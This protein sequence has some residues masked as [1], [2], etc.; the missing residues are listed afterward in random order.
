MR[1]VRSE[2]QTPSSAQS[3]AL[4]FIERNGPASVSEMAAHRHVKHQSMRLVIAQLEQQQLVAR[5][6]DPVDGRKQLIT[7]TDAGHAALAQG[8]TLRSDWLAS[9]LRQ[10]ATATQLDTL[11]AAVEILE[12]L[13]TDDERG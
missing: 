4:G 6:P 12:R 3:E 11:M 8:R 10:K 13:V 7:L 9:Q 2:A 5:A 1:K